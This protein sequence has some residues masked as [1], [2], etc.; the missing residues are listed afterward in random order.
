[1]NGNMDD[2]YREMVNFTRALMAFNE[3][4]RASIRDLEQHHDRVSPHW[5]DEMRRH[6]DQQW[7]PFRQTIKHYNAVEGPSYVEFLHIKAEATRR[8]LE[9]G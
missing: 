3:R 9:G 4:L 6:Y 1:M 8:F 5:Q 2:Q 7:E